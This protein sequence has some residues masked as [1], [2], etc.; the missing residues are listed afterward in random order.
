M[1]RC[2]AQFQSTERTVL[3]RKSCLFVQKQHRI[4]QLASSPN[5]TWIMLVQDLKFKLLRFSN[6]VHSSTLQ[7]LVRLRVC[8][9]LHAAGLSV[10]CQKQCTSWLAYW[11]LSSEQTTLY[12]EQWWPRR[13]HGIC[14]R[15]LLPYLV[16]WASLLFSAS[17]AQQHSTTVRI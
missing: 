3:F 13:L 5:N 8:R 11:F 14:T 10:E 12:S 1:C 16:F 4:D 15:L 9:H 6:V 7:R 17:T 2:C